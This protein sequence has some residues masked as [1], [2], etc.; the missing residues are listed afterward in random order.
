MLVRRIISV[1]ALGALSITLTGCV[2][3]PYDPGAPYAYGPCCAVYPE[4]PGYYYGPGYYGGPTFVYAH[5]YYGE[6]FR[7]GG[8]WR[9]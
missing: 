6:H 4:Y 1:C 9:H 3:A 2:I 5:G 8:Y 7:G